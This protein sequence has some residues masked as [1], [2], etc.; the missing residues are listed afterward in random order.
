MCKDRCIQNYI[1]KTLTEE[2]PWEDCTKMAV[3]EIVCD[4][5]D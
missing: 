3:R 5:V 4:V 2:L 1:R